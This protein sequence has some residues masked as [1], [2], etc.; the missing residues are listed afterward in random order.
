MYFFT[1]LI[2]SGKI[3]NAYY[4]KQAI[5]EDVNT[6]VQLI[7]ELDKVPPNE[8]KFARLEQ[9]ANK[10]LTELKEATRNGQSYSMSR[11]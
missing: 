1:V 4:Q 9:E 7:S 2:K 11:I 5:L 6:H 8:R 3:K 10:T